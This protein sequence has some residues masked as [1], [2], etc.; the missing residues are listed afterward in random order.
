MQEDHRY[1]EGVFQ[2]V[3]KAGCKDLMTNLDLRYPVGVK[4]KG[5]GQKGENSML[6]KW[7]QTVKLGDPQKNLL[8]HPQKIVLIRVRPCAAL[9]SEPGGGG[10]IDR[11]GWYANRNASLMPGW[12]D[13]GVGFRVCKTILILE[14]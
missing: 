1:W 5:L 14:S 13:R 7:I 11:K 9:L 3:D 10:L 6:A 4:P 2:S 12:G 8:G